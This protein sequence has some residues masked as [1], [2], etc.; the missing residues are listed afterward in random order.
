[1]GDG[2]WG[3]GGI[4]LEGLPLQLRR[5]GPIGL[6]PGRG[7]SERRARRLLRREAECLPPVARL[8]GELRPLLPQPGGTGLHRL[9]LLGQR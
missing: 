3:E 4:G 1:M 6:L 7:Q 5:L 9:S 2:G 8:Q